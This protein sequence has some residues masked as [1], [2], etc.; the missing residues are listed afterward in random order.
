MS[1]QPERYVRRKRIVPIFRDFFRPALEYL[2]PPL[3][4]R[5]NIGVAEYKRVRFN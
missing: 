5:L 4:R 3:F 2:D 1:R